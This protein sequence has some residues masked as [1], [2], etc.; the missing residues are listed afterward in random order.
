MQLAELN[1]A[2][3]FDYSACADCHE[4]KPEPLTL[5]LTDSQYSIFSLIAG[6]SIL[7]MYSYTTVH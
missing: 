5:D 6:H 3:V 1:Q 2:L 7:N 4:E